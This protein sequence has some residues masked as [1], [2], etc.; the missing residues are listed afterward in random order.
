MRIAC[1]KVKSGIS[2]LVFNAFRS[3]WPKALS[4]D[5]DPIEMFHK[6]LATAEKWI[7]SFGASSFFNQKNVI[8]IGC[9]NGALCVRAVQNGAKRV[10]GVEINNSAAEDACKIIYS[11]YPEM[12][13][14]IDCTDYQSI[15]SPKYVGQFDIVISQNSF[16]HF[17][18]PQKVLK[19]M[20]DLLKPGG[21]IY[22]GFSPLWNSPFGS[23]LRSI[24]PLP[25][26][27][28][29]AAK[30]LLKEHNLVRSQNPITSYKDIG[31]NQVAFAHY[32]KIFYE[33]DGCDVVMFLCNHS[34]RQRLPTAYYFLKIMRALP[35]LK[36]YL[37]IS[38]HVV[39][40]KHE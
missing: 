36:E 33:I 11:Q 34:I 29:W 23:H 24:Y 17:E 38:L 5:D 37:P 40:R 3:S 30:S 1:S 31:L 7:N 19:R 2:K 28:L 35:F 32:K 12:R 25:W 6:D 10:L 39:I 22:A 4:W 16:E 20:V 26:A 27:H 14:Q 8:E 18:Q 21:Y 15:E 9:G 13:N